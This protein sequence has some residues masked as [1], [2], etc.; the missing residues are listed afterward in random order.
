MK[1]VLEMAKSKMENELKNY[2]QLKSEF[3]NKFFEFF[4]MIKEKHGLKGM[5]DVFLE[6]N[7]IGIKDYHNMDELPNYWTESDKIEES[8]FYSFTDKIYMPL[9]EALGK[10]ELDEVPPKPNLFDRVINRI[11]T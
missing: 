2:E 9:Q 6:F 3:N 5:N 11:K 10:A 4:D 1:V 7:F 8:F